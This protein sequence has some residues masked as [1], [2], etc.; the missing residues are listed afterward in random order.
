VETS[1]EEVVARRYRV[2]QV[3]SSSADERV[4]VAEDTQERRTCALRIV[5]LARAADRRSAELRLERELAVSTLVTSDHIAR[6][7]ELGDVDADRRYLA[8]EYLE[9]QSLE[10]SIED[11]SAL[12]IKTAVDVVLQACEGLAVAHAAGVVH[13]AI[14]PSCL[15]LTH[16]REGTPRV[17]ILDFGCAGHVGESPPPPVAHVGSY[18]APELGASG[19]VDVRSDVYS[20][21]RILELLLGAEG[22]DE[23]DPA[24]VPHELQRSVACCLAADPPGRFRDM[25]AVAAALAPFGGSDARAVA[26]RVKRLSMVVA[27]TGRADLPRT[28]LGV[29]PRAAISTPPPPPSK[30]AERKRP[31]AQKT[32]RTSRMKT[33]RMSPVV[34]E[35]ETAAKQPAPTSDPPRSSR[36]PMSGPLVGAAKSPPDFDVRGRRLLAGLGALLALVLA[37]LLWPS[38][39]PPPPRTKATRASPPPETAVPRWPPPPPVGASQAEP[40]QPSKDRAEEPAVPR[41]GDQVPSLEPSSAVPPT[42]KAALT[43]PHP[44]ADEGAGPAEGAGLSDEQEE[45]T[46]EDPFSDRK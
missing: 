25:A 2:D 28:L 27:D 36:P 35:K 24:R 6:V 23:S 46:D 32:R 22:E 10:R 15:F 45:V 17:K 37:V 31:A 43:V 11:S 9:G 19:P 8:M 42:A 13:R 12:P 40:M 14:R 26:K 7:Y 39:A 18:S 44:S 33:R 3:L 34:A 38:T 5:D 20:I 1:T 41:N 21:G 16:P 30:R 29:G 4:V